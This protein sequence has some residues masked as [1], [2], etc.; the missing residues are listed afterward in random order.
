MLENVT[1]M[2][3]WEITILAYVFIIWAI[4]TL[5]FMDYIMK[6]LIEKRE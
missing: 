4:S 3:W 2:S 6:I 5:K 1:N